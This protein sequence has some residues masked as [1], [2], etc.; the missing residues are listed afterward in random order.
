MNC[1]V[2]HF[3]FC[4]SLCMFRITCW[5]GNLWRLTNRTLWPLC[6]LCGKILD[7]WPDFFNG[8]RTLLVPFA[9]WHQFWEFLSGIGHMFVCPLLSDE[10]RP[11]MW[12]P[13][14]R[15]CD[16]KVP[17]VELWWSKPWLMG[18]GRE[19]GA[20]HISSPLFCPFS[21]LFSSILL[22]MLP[23]DVMGRHTCW[24]L[25][26]V[27]LPP[28]DGMIFRTEVWFSKDSG[29]SNCFVCLFFGEATQHAG[30]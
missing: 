10:V 16:L 8:Y 21:V 1:E 2:F 5:L 25:L 29:K 15:W 26:C 7:D 30:S 13:M 23:Q 9:F 22:S 28:C 4:K 14:T 24:D 11:L 3:I 27:F 6:I 19:K 20:Q 12:L 17:G 18:Y